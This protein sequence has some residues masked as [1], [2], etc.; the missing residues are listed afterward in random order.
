MKKRVSLSLIEKILS[1]GQRAPTA[2]SFQTYS[3]IVTQSATKKK[4]VADLSGQSFVK[5]APLFVLVCADLRRFRRVLDTIGHDYHLKHGHGLTTVLYSIID[6][7]LAAENIVTAAECYG[8]ATCLVG[9]ILNEIEAISE[10]FHLPEGVL[11]LFGI[12]IGYGAEDPPLRPRWP[13]KAVMHHEVY[14]EI[15]FREIVEYLNYADE[16]LR[17]EGY[18][19][20]YSRR[21]YGYRD[22]LRFK[23]E[24][25]NWIARVD[26]KLSRFIVRN[27]FSLILSADS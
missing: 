16:E 6:A 24:M 7:T 8:L 23:T 2:C 3:F 9:A 20:K 22:H 17:R 27:G 14:R 13:L 18:Y 21:K 11:P 5:N 1:A 12:S 15:S 4:R 25:S 26:R 10:V 19:S